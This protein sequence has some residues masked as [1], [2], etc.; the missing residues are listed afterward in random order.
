[1]EAKGFSTDVQKGITLQVGESPKINIALNMGQ[2]TEEVVV[3]SNAAMVQTDTASV[4]QV[5]DQARMVELP[6]NGRVPTQLIMLSGAANDV[7]PAN[8]HSDLTGSKSYFTAD[9][10]SVAG[11]Q[12]NGTNYLLDGGEN[13]DTFSNVNLPLPFPDALQEFSVETSALSARYGMHAGAVVN[14]VTK[15]ST[16]QFHG[17]LFEYVRNGDANAID[18][19]ATKQDSLKRNQ[20][21]GTLGAP[22]IKNKLFGFFGYQKTVI[23]TAPPS[24]YSYVPTQAALNGDFSQLESAGCQSSGVAR[25]ILDPTTGKAFQGSQIP[26]A[27]F[28]QQ[29]LN[30]LKYVPVATDPCGKITYAFPEPQSEQQIFGRVDSTLSSKHS[31]FGHIFL[32]NYSSPGP[33]SDTNILL[34]QLRGVIDHS[35]SAIVGDTYTISPTIVNSAHAGYT[36]LAVVRGPSPNGID[37]SKIGVNVPYEPVSNFLY[38]TV[39]GH[40]TAGCGSCAPA[41]LT[42]NNT[43]LSDDLDI[44]RGRHHISAGGEWVNYWSKITFTT[45]GAGVFS[46]NGQSTNDALGDFMLGLPQSFVQ[47]NLHEMDGR[48]NYYGA[49][50]HDVYQVNKRLTAQ[51]GV[52][53]EPNLWGH[54]A[55]NRMQHFN[56]AAFTA[57]TISSVYTNAPAGLQFPGDPGMPSGFSTNSPWKFEPRA[58][59][60]WDT[61]G[62]GRQ[63][64]RA[65]YG[66]FYDLMGLGYWEDATGN[67]PWGSTVTLDS[68]SGGFTNPYAGYPGGSPFPSPQPPPHNVSYPSSGTYYTYPHAAHQEYTNVWNLSYEVQPFKNWLFS[69]GYLGNTTVHVW[70]GENKNAGVYIPGTCN[71]APCSTEANVNQRRVL[72][73]QNPVAGSFYADIFQAD[74]GGVSRYQAL[75]LKG[76]HRFAQN[77]T[78]LANYTYS[79]CISDADSSGDLGGAQTQNPNSLKGEHGNCGFDIRQS[80]NLSFVGVSPRLK[81][82]L[83]DD[84]VGTW[85]LSPILTMRSGT[86]FSPLTGTDNSLTTIGLDR[87]NVVGNPYVRNLKTHQW[88]TPSGFVPNPIGTFG[89]AGSDSLEGPKDVNLDAALSREFIV[90]ERMKFDLRFEAFNLANHPNFSNPD[91]TLSDST[92]GVIQSDAGPRI[93]QFAGRFQF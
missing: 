9:S 38:L 21:G 53:W 17:D 46:F 76:Q 61:T 83:A 65:G 34:T 12:A 7:G 43:Q 42:Q 89:N 16:N 6:L 29:A 20:F 86:W 8:G 66:L 32:A 22:I 75:L 56:Q 82:R 23:R 88:L 62:S 52:R 26:T 79:H 44:V 25:T 51:L 35:V 74:D 71:G 19:F 24:S 64:I 91:N 92:F 68:P 10:I 63:I 33:F 40:F 36:R 69:A 14:A 28:N 11:G 39:N 55:A 54:E 80:F 70:S 30:F 81:N 58:G 73:L 93:L 67:A 15:S 41:D 84:L 48:Q 18:Y 87:P 50:A 77:Y 78:I 5:I 3:T 31:L 37:F 47:G 57:G 2:V 90:R 85:T 13:M 45:L 27:R 49:Y 1:V 72:Y 59:V 60:A 4:T